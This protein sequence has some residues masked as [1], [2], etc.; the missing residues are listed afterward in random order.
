VLVYPWLHTDEMDIYP[1]QI[2]EPGG[3]TRV[4]H[5]HFRPESPKV[6]K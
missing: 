3:L 4:F 5:L 1:N 2:I 6:P